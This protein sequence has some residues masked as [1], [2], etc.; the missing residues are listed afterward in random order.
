MQAP[1]VHYVERTQ[2]LANPRSLATKVLTASSRSCL[3]SMSLTL[4]NRLDCF[5]TAAFSMS[6]N[7]PAT[8][9][10]VSWS[11]LLSETSAHCRRWSRNKF[12]SVV[13]D[14]VAYHLHSSLKNPKSCWLHSVVRT[15]RTKFCSW[16]RGPLGLDSTL[17]TSF[18]SGST[19]GPGLG[20]MNW[21][22]LLF[23]G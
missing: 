4:F 17:S 11:F 22:H 23:H 8:D 18:N 16:S 19:T 1:S 9:P 6:S 14:P 13:L 20:V 21:A 7:S 3:A 10:M 2:M 5:S 12:S 15:G